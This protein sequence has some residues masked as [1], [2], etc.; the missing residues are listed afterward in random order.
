MKTYTDTDI[1]N[2]IEET[3]KRRIPIKIQY[4]MLTDEWSNPT[5]NMEKGYT[6][7]YKTLRE[8]CWERMKKEPK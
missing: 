4:D 7:K 3:G 2:W 8:A 6:K 1:V 5:S